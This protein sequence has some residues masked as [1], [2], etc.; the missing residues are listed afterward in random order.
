M[1]EY[2]SK[3]S[4]NFL[5]VIMSTIV[6]Q[7]ISVIWFALIFAKTWDKY[8]GF[9]EEEL[10]KVKADHNKPKTIY[11]SLLEQFISA[12][13]YAVL[14][15]NLNITSLMGAGI[16]GLVIWAGFMATVGVN[17]VIWHRE[18]AQFYIL[19]QACYL[20]RTVLKGVVYFYIVS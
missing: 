1:F 14:M 12:Y 3:L 20:V 6:G 17:E 16:L 5:G 2:L 9:N 10:K 7:I 19:N 4:V 15:H 18:K 13:F 8:S 11:F